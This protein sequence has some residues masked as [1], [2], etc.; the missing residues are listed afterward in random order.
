[1]VRRCIQFPD[2]SKFI[3]VNINIYL[4]FIN[5]YISLFS[6]YLLKF[7]SNNMKSIDLIR[8]VNT[9]LS[10]LKWMTIISG[11][12]IM[13]VFVV[14]INGTYFGKTFQVEIPY[15]L[16][17]EEVDL[18][19]DAGAP[20]VDSRVYKSS[21]EEIIFADDKSRYKINNVIRVRAGSAWGIITLIY[22][23]LYILLVVFGIVLLQK[24][25]RNSS[26]IT[27][28]MQS[29][30]LLIRQIAYVVFAFAI[31]KWTNG[32]FLEFLSMKLNPDNL[33]KSFNFSLST[34]SLIPVLYG[35]L[36]LI[37][38]AVFENGVELK[39]EAKLTI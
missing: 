5:K 35:F 11:I 24:L 6:N 1:M 19:I 12:I 8:K 10:V 9:A 31:L 21:G 14:N 16:S 20:L 7:K 2:G 22:G 34:S 37:L 25:L 29:N 23:V 33:S 26:E 28:F 4:L 39:E 13:I 30:V 27:P 36:I 3:V 15:K 17:H 18:L 38:A 32:I